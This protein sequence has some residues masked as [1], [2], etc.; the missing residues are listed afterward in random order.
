MNARNL[1]SATLLAIGMTA[2][3]GASDCQP[4]WDVAVGNPGPA[5]SWVSAWGIFDDG[6]GEALYA[7]GGF[8]GITGVDGTRKIARWDGTQWSSVGGGIAGGSGS[9]VQSMVVFDDGS[10]PALYVAGSFVEALDGTSMPRVGRWD[11]TSWSAVG[12]G[13]DAQVLELAVF[14]DGNGPTLYAAGVFNFSGDTAV[15][16]IARWDGNE[17]QPVGGGTN[18]PIQALYV[19]DDGNGEVLYAGGQFN[20]VGQIVANRIAKWDGNS[21]S[22]IGNGVAETVDSIHSFDDGT[23]D[24]LYVGG[25]F[26]E[27]TGGINYIARWDASATDWVQVGGGLSGG[28]AVNTM[29]VYD[30]GSGSAL[31]V[32]GWFSHAEGQQVNGIAK[33]N[34]QE[35]SALDSGLNSDPYALVVWD[36]GAGDA[37]FAGGIFS[38]AGGKSTQRAATW[39]GCPTGTV[40][41]L[42]GD[43]VVN[44]SDLLILLGAWGDCPQGRDCPADLNGDGTVNVSDLLILLANWG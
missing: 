31:Y 3:A 21:W 26:E 41:D 1:T 44:V 35:W 15:N 5:S 38:V 14:D 6:N 37:L 39:R 32:G 36:D 25:F 12:V 9:R 16:H 10:G 43:G 8:T 24:T 20:G 22:A 33:W 17:W 30:D 40:G 11:G 23:G 34:G 18:A 7:G 29:V 4:F 2:T 19:W 42:N 28:G 27:F 13:F